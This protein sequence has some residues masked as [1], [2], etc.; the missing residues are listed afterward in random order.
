M[1]PQ[2]NV[3]RLDPEDPRMLRWVYVMAHVG[4]EGHKFVYKSAFFHW[5]RGQ[6]LMIEDYA[7]EGVD[8][9]KDPELPLSEGE[10]WDERGKKDTIHHVFNFSIYLIFIL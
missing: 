2:V 4:G 9:C 10:K 5:L 6:L 8:F 3:S 7:Y 1:R